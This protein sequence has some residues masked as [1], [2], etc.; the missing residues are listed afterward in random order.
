M[1]PY[2]LFIVAYLS[3]PLAFVVLS[4]MLRSHA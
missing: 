2:A 4:M 3:V 1:R